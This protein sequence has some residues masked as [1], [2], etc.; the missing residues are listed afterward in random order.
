MIFRVRFFDIDK[1]EG[2]R[3][4]KPFMHPVKQYTTSPV[5]L[6]SL[7]LQAF[8]DSYIFIFMPFICDEN[9]ND[10]ED[11][12]ICTHWMEQLNDEVYMLTLKKKKNNNNN[13]NYYYPIIYLCIIIV[14]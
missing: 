1:H 11:D 7:P 4:S 3:N 9:V 13:N 8:Y 12:D 5:A 2:I 6:S 14:T 10:S